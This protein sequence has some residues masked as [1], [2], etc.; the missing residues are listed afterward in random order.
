[1]CSIPPK[2]VVTMRVCLFGTGD[3][4]QSGDQCFFC[5][6]NLD[7]GQRRLVAQTAYHA[8]FTGPDISYFV[9]SE[10]TVG[11]LLDAVH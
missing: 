2:K 3:G 11:D 6:R 4:E 8:P 1:M 9:A 5:L 7:P 10:G